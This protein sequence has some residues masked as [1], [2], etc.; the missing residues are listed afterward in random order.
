MFVQFQQGKNGSPI[1]YVERKVAFPPRGAS[2]N[3]GEW[4]EVEIAGENPAGTVKFLTLIEN[5]SA[6]REVIGKRGGYAYYSSLIP[7]EEGMHSTPRRML[8]PK[9]Y[10]VGEDVDV[11]LGE[12]WRWRIDHEHKKLLPIERIYASEEERVA[13]GKVRH[14]KRIAEVLMGLFDIRF[15]C[16]ANEW[17]PGYIDVNTRGGSRL[18]ERVDVSTLK[19]TECIPFIAQHISTW[20]ETA[21]QP[22]E[23]TSDD[24]GGFQ[25]LHLDF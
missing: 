2:V 9:E 19:E 13:D 25:F 12:P 20:Q 14:A 3:V 23:Q 24:D 11:S 22:C 17:H 6:K 10:K 21:A 16:Y 5:F 15:R 4:W 1:A 7:L 8:N 18:L